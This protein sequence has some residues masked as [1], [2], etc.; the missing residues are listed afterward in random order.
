MNL[1]LWA[2][3]L[4]MFGVSAWAFVEPQ[5]F[6]RAAFGWRYAYPELSQPNDAGLLIRSSTM[7]AASMALFYYA[8]AVTPWP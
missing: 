7:L 5:R 2:G 4:A 1:M 6:W 8:V 3:V